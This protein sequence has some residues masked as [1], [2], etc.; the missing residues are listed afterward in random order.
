MIN[1]IPLV[2]KKIPFYQ[3]YNQ[4]AKIKANA[5]FSLTNSNIL[6][7]MVLIGVKKNIRKQIYKCLFKFNVLVILY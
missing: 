1:I 5:H 7:R 4:N 3:Q 2:Y 6:N